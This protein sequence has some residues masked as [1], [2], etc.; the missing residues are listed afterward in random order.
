MRLFVAVDVDADT[1]ARIGHII[2][3]LRADSEQAR[4]GARIAWI[5]PDR[6]HLTLQFIGEVSGDVT[7]AVLARLRPA[8]DL[9]SFDMRFG[10]L[11]TFPPSGRPRVVWLSVDRGAEGLGVLH[12]EVA[13]RLADVRFRR[14]AR[15]FSP[16]LTLA[17]VK[18][19]GTPADTVRLVRAQLEP[20]GGCTIDHVTLYQS[21]PSPRGPTYTPLLVTALAPKGG[22]A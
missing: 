20:A 21:R 10:R 2:D 13:R 17:R 22:G 3:A 11:G 19:G 18:E 7:D 5:V 15:A 16:H 12:A 6:L 4:S 9:P 14:D 1:R 8:F